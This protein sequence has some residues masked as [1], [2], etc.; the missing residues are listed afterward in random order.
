MGAFQTEFAFTL[1]KGYIESEGDTVHRD[2][3]MRLATAEDEILPWRDPRVKENPA[4]ASII[5]LSNAIVKLGTL[6][7]V[8]TR[9]ISQLYSQDFEFL[10]N[11]Y[12]TINQY[13]YSIIKVKCP[14]CEHDIEVEAGQPG[15]RQ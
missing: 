6:E 15:E 3:L 9:I 4:Y 14:K 7:M 1:P 12:N 10:L 13:G 5:I 11:L 2:G 8:T